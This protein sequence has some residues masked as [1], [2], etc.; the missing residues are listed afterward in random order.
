M[1]SRRKPNTKVVALPPM[2]DNGTVDREQYHTRN[3]PNAMDA[4][5]IAWETWWPGAIA[6]GV[7]VGWLI[8]RVTRGIWDSAQWTASRFF[9]QRRAVLGEKR[10]EKLLIRSGYRILSRQAEHTWNIYV[11]GRATPI[12]LRA[13]LLV[14]RGSKTYV[15]EVKTGRV[16]PLIR[17]APT[18]RQ[19]IEYRLAYDVDG[20]LLVD[21]ERDAIR[22]V[23]FG[24]PSRRQSLWGQL[25]ALVMGALLGA[26]GAAWW[27][28][29]L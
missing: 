1:Y 2:V 3:Q 27:F 15:A 13:D 21:M 25:W 17:T 8:F 23:D 26:G 11:D 9:R 19:L 12:N 4:S 10:A 22:Y 24:I 6:V 29:T 20:V 5:N 16:A 7:V 14:S 18:R 28:H